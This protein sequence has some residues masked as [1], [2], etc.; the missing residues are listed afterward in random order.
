MA[1]DRAEGA[2]HVQEPAAEIGQR[3]ADRRGRER[4][5]KT[6]FALLQRQPR[7]AARGDIYID[8]DARARA[9]VGVVENRGALLDPA[10]FAVGPNDAELVAPIRV[11]PVEKRRDRPRH[12]CPIVR[13]QTIEPRLVRRDRFRRVEPVGYFELPIDRHLIVRYVPIKGSHLA[14]DV[15]KALQLLEALALGDIETDA[16]DAHGLSVFVAAYAAARSDPANFPV[17]A[18]D[19]KLDVQELAARGRELLF[20]KPL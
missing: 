1:D 3:H 4:P 14:G 11:A 9:P 2:I 6:V 10:D 5:A 7:L 12:A 18:H 16:V 19:A 13:V 15:R 20:P 17:R 8:T